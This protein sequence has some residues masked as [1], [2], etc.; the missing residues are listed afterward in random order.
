MSVDDVYIELRRQINKMPV[1][2]P[3]TESGV[4]IRILKHLF[5]PKEAEIAIHLNV[6]PETLE[7]VYDR[8]KKTNQTISHKELEKILDCLVLKGSIMLD[9]KDGQKL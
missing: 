7:R 3:P 5:T 2:M 8:V 1:G 9:E 4:E 6:F